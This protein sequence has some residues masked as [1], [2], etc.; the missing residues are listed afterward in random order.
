LE[1]Y[2]FFHDASKEGSVVMAGTEIQEVL[3]RGETVVDWTAS[4][5]YTEALVLGGK[6]ELLSFKLTLSASFWML[7]FS[8]CMWRMV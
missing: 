5:V 1:R 6:K 4:I 8:A 2:F 7:S 3:K